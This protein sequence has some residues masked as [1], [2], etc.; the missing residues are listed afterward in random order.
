MAKSMLLS[1]PVNNWWEIQILCQP[2][3]EETIFWRLQNFGCQGI[4]S[5]IKGHQL[6]LRTYMLEE[7][8]SLLD[9]AALSLWLEQD[10]MMMGLEPPSTRWILINE[11]DWSTSWKQ[12]WKPQ[13]IGDLF[14]VYP[15]WIEPPPDITRHALRLDP[16]SAFGTGTHATTQ[17]CLEA[18]EMR[19]WGIKPEQDIIVADIGCGSGILGIGAL[20][21]GA[22]QVYAVDNDILAIKA[23]NH[24]RALNDLPPEQLWVQ[25]GTIEHLRHAMPVLADGFVCNILADVIIEL[26]P[27]FEHIVKANGWGI[28]SGILLDQV[29]KVADALES[30]KWNIATLWR[31]QDWACLTIR[32]N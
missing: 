7:K 21:L 26:V 27:E 5:Q 24:N 4:A 10:A 18:L 1:A 14:T 22:R 3:L 30:H 11:E 20:M 15:A 19:L 23:T 12:H 6:Y 29:P 28:L 32:R 9:L 16:G 25:E 17:L 8:A 13:D 2:V 31:R